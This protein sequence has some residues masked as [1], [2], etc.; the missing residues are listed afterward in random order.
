MAEPSREEV[1]LE[2][3]ARGLL[4]PD[5]QAVVAEMRARGMLGTQ[6]DIEKDN[7]RRELRMSEKEYS[8]YAKE[9]KAKGLPGRPQ[10]SSAQLAGDIAS[11]QLLLQDEIVGAGE[12]IKQLATGDKSIIDRQAWDDA[13]SA[14][15]RGADRVRAEREV[16]GEEFGNYA[17]IPQILGGL[18]M[19][20]AKVPAVASAAVSKVAPQVSNKL[21]AW[22][23]G[24]GQSAKVGAT[25]GGI[26]GVTGGEGGVAQRALGGVGGAAAGAALAPA[27]SHVVAPAAA[28]AV[29]KAV[30]A[31]APARQAIA[32]KFSGDPDA[33]LL[34]ALQRQN[35]TPATAQA[36]LDEGADLARY[37]S[38]KTATQTDLPEMIVD[39]GPAVQ[40]L[41]RAVEA[42]PGEG[43]TIAQRE[44]NLRQ[45]GSL[46]GTSPKDPDYR[47][48]QHERVNDQFARGLRVTN[49]DYHKTKGRLAAEQKEDAGPLYNEFRDLTNGAG[50]PLRIDVGDILA[51]SEADDIN[52]SPIHKR[53][54]QRARAQFMDEDVVRDVGRDAN[55]QAIL[56]K[57]AVVAKTPNYK[58]GT[59]RFQSGKEAVDD[60]ITEAEAKGRSSEVRLLTMLKNELIDAADSATMIPVRDKAGNPVLD[61]AGNVQWRSVYREARDV[62]SDK[63]GMLDALA[64][65]RTFMKGDSEVTAAEYKALSTGEKRMFRVGMAQ[66][67]RVDT[68]GKVTGGDRVAYFDR[69]NVQAVMSEIMSSKEYQ[70]I[71]Q[72]HQREAAMTTSKRMKEGSPTARIDQE[73]EDLNWL[74]RQAS[75]MGQSGGAIG[76]A[77]MKASQVVQK[78]T[79]MREDDALA[80]SK[81][82]YERDRGKQRVTLQRLEKKYGRPRAQRG[83][84]AAIRE[85]QR[86]QRRRL[87]NQGFNQ[88]M[89]RIGGII[90]GDA[91]A[92]RQDASP[93]Q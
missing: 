15:S 49:A 37:G 32:A 91:A 4:S 75:D 59:S 86:E 13:G 2:L 64:K 14:Y 6:K 18:G 41:S 58:L 90:G 29:R 34:R 20:A 19:V 73:V 26:T 11:D 39:T 76:Y 53:L 63:Q 82:L 70:R 79:R 8:E 25:Y 72:L 83:I 46:P 69:P 42:V 47:V 12:F 67:A 9:R 21:A 51:R 38:G 35:M 7:V 87:Q 23:G 48:G 36:H 5:R 1:L 65:G 68:G 81:M 84:A 88:A 89:P 31:T 16:A 24:A 44:L 52:L 93:R 30:D 62:Y 40:R 77:V 71:A 50:E 17:L 55:N 45:R 66:Q 28:F 27:L 22:L 60:M 57:D 61:A 33:I 85:I 78:L 92:I 3:E 10:A 56:G 54:M 74:G 43:S 80:L